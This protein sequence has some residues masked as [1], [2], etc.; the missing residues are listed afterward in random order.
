MSSKID[1]DLFD[2]QVRTYGE[3][4]VKKMTTSSVVICGLNNGLGAEIAK[5]LALGG[6]KNI[7]LCDNNIITTDDLK[8]GFY[9]TDKEV[10]KITSQVLVNK[11]QELNL[12]NTYLPYLK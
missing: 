11:I 4:A 7:Y 12:S 3:D 1:L 5:N 10:G 6:I 8:T 9:F 2:R